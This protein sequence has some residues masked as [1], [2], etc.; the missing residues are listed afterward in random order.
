MAD[1]SHR[2]IPNLLHLLLFLALTIAILFAAEF[3][4]LLLSHQPLHR[5][6]SNQKLQLIVTAGVYLLTLWVAGVLFPAL[7]GRSFRGGIQWNG[8]GA[9]LLPLAI[10]GLL[11][12]FTAEAVSS[13]LPTPHEMPI[14]DVFQ[15]PGIIW[16]LVIFGTVLAPLFEEIVFRGLL[17]PALANAVDW[18]RLPHAKTEQSELAHEQ[19]RHSEG[20]ST[21]ALVAS[22]LVTSVL[23]AL[24][25]AP[26]LGF[27]WAPVTLLVCVSLV[28]CGV[29]IWTK[30]VAASTLV[31]GVYNMAAFILIFVSTGGFRHM[32][33]P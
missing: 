29:R 6:A 18:L 21:P 15:A 1:D 28:L 4:T 11:L 30:S 25:H 10:L 31:H 23:F 14:E 22:S 27:N 5:A 9:K 17:L 12:G 16:F 2:R 3:A 24:I 32:N 19:W 13:H 7:W 20:W 26:Q 33:Q 8:G